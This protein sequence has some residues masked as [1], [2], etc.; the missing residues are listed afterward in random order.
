MIKF[1]A[2]K[3]LL[4][5][6][7]FQA[8]SPEDPEYIWPDAYTGDIE[9]LLGLLRQ[10]PSYQI[11]KNHAHCGLRSK[12]LPALDYIKDV[13]EGVG[14]KSNSD[15]LMWI[16]SKEVMPKNR[17]QFIVGGKDVSGERRR[18]FDLAKALSVNGQIGPYMMSV[19]K[20]AKDLFTAEELVWA[21]SEADDTKERMAK[22]SVFRF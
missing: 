15:D 10:C 18:V 14:L 9:N 1:L 13:L 7:P 5:L 16:K 12:I 11:D 21:R 4:S 2:K 17:P 3:D 19:E 8:V 22:S 20:A 6:I